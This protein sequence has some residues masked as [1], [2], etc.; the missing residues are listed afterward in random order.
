[1]RSK[2][3]FKSLVYD[4][5]D[6]LWQEEADRKIRFNRRIRFYS[7]AS[8]ALAACIALAVILPN[9]GFWSGLAGSQT[10]GSRPDPNA[11]I[12]GEAWGPNED[13]TPESGPAVMPPAQ[14]P[15]ESGSAVLPPAQIPPETESGVSDEILQV[16][17]TK[18]LSTEPLMGDGI[19]RL[20]GS[21]ES[22]Y[23][24]ITDYEELA[25][26]FGGLCG[27]LTAEA[28][29]G[30]D[31]FDEERFVI[32]IARDEGDPGDNEVEYSNV[33]LE[34]GV[35]YLDREY[36]YGGEHDVPA[37]EVRCVD[38]VVINFYGSDPS[39]ITFVDVLK[40]GENR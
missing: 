19:G 21:L 17:F 6:R 24:I 14:V 10:N 9:M 30:N 25:E 12:E 29:F 32:A 3:E 31:I 35:L 15:P 27:D 11:D 23:Q 33:T 5:R 16:K 18:T 38:F 40:K 13:Q 2:E 22:E 8:S 28:V 26:I 20:V 39:Q 34:D 4:K 1:M 37:V 36:T 7:V